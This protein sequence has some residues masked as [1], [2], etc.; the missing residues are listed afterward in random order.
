MRPSIPSLVSGNYIPINP[1]N[2]MVNGF[3]YYLEKREAAN[4][5][6][7]LAFGSL[8]PVAAQGCFRNLC[9][10]TK[11]WA[12]VSFLL[13]TPPLCWRW[14]LFKYLISQC[15]PRSANFSIHSRGIG[16]IGLEFD[17]Q[18]AAGSSVF[19]CQGFST[20]DSTVA[21]FTYERIAIRKPDS[22]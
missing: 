22:G 15:S 18:S 4:L 14:W 11:H 1:G 17:E 12:H 9:W 6:R 3:W 5:F 19:W 13:F 2:E 10:T 20:V 8:S 16:K 7:P 21:F